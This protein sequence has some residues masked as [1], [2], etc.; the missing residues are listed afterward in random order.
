MRTELRRLIVVF[1]D[2]PAL[3]PPKTRTRMPV[4]ENEKR[5][6]DVAALVELDEHA[7]HRVGVVRVEREPLVGVVAGGPEPLV[8]LNDRRAVALTPAPGPLQEAVASE[9]L[10]T[11][12]QAQQFALDLT[13]RGDAGVVGAEDPLRPPARH[14]LVADQR[15]LNQIGRAHV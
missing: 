14:P 13:L 11:G 2:M 3:V 8:L 15:V 12:A 7:Q 10:A 6:V 1:C 4:K 5:L 9:L